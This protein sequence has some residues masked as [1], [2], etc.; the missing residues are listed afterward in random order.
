MALQKQNEKPS[1]DKQI[2]KEA[3]KSLGVD[4]VIEKK[5]TAKTQVQLKVGDEDKQP[6]KKPELPMKPKEEEEEPGMGDVYRSVMAL[7]GKMTGLE[8]RMNGIE[9]AVGKQPEMTADPEG[10]KVK[11]P[12]PVTAETSTSYG[13]EPSK[14]AEGDKV[15]MTEKTIEDTVKKY[16]NAGAVKV[17]TP[18][19]DAIDKGFNGSGMDNKPKGG[20]ILKMA[21]ENR[22][23]AER[24]A[25][26]KQMIPASIGFSVPGEV[27]KNE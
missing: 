5:N 27:M 4:K 16:L 17:D 2:M 7:T 20:D 14:E 1:E 15:G 23:Y 25:V 18:R 13:K 12:K 26:L 22:S 9:K 3:L 8:D 21:R 11:L 24:L 10:G 6:P 19:P